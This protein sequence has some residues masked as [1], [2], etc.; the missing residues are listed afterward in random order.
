MLRICLL[1][2]NLA[3]QTVSCDGQCTFLDQ[4]QTRVVVVV[5]GEGRVSLHFFFVQ[6]V[7]G[8]FQLG[9]FRRN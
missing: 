3:M 7:S 9:I 4:Q 8:V 1:E 2:N 5:G 6:R